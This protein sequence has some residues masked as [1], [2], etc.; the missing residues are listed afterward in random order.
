MADAVLTRLLEARAA[1]VERIA[2]IHTTANH[3]LNNPNNKVQDGGTSLDK[4]GY[5]KGL[6]DQLKEID[7]A[8]NR[9]KQVVAD[10][11]DGTAGVFEYFS[12]VDV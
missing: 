6:M 11:E 1:I 12:R 8:I 9:H 3:P 10:S 5:L 4:V 7:E 2:A